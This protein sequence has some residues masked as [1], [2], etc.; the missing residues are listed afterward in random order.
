MKDCKLARQSFESLA[1][2]FPQ[3]TWVVDASGN[4]EYFNRR[5]IDYLGRMSEEIDR[6]SWA[7]LI[8]PEDLPGVV[9]A[10]E[11][12]VGTNG[13]L[14]AE[15]RVRRWDGEYRW[16]LGRAEPTRGSDG[17]LL[18]CGTLTDIEDRK[19]A[20]FALANTVDLLR[21]VCDTTPDAVY[22]KDR[23]GKYLL[24]N[25]AAA[26]FL[27]KRV[28]DILGK[29][30]AAFLEPESLRSV[31]EFDR[32]T[33]GSEVAKTEEETLTAA[34]TTRTFLTTKAPYRD[35][36]GRTIALLGISRDVTEKKRA[37][38][39]LRLRDRAIR[40]VPQG[41]VIAD[42][43]GPDT[44]IVYASPGFEQL[45]GYTSA[46]VIGKNCRFLQGPNTDLVQVSLV[47]DAIRAGK[48]CKVELLNYR[49]DGTTFWNE[50]AISPVR[51]DADRLT[52]FVAVQ[53]DVT[54]RRSLEGQL[55]QS[56][57]MEAVGRLAGGIAHDFNNILTVICG[58]SRLLLDEMP[59][60]EEWWDSIAEI[61]AAGKRAGDSIRQL[62]AFS[63]QTVLEP[64]LIDPNELVR[65]AE[66]LLRPLIGEDIELTSQLGAD[67]GCIMADAAQ[68]EQALVN[69]CVN[70][71]DAMPSG[72]ELTIRTRRKE[73]VDRSSGADPGTYAAISVTDTGH[74]MDPATQTR[75][76]EP[77][78]TTKAIGKGTGLGLSLVY[79]FVRQSGGFIEVH[80]ELG[81]GATFEIFLPAI[82][83]SEATKSKAAIRNLPMPRGSETIL[84]VEDE[85]SVRTLAAR[86]LRGCGYSVFEATDG[87]DAL[88]VAEG[89]YDGIDLVLTDVVMP[90]GMG[91]R[92]VAECV[93]ASH[94]DAKVLYVSGYTDDALVR[95]GVKEDSI[96]FLQKPFSPDSLARK[97][98]EVLDQPLVYE[99]I[100][101]GPSPLEEAVYP[102]TLLD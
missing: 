94:P 28:E 86:V 80:S 1:D 100:A 7:D 13:P 6:D 22:V 73:V 43:S 92:K 8:H 16:H 66:K 77:F 34:G 44:P 57:K 75:I 62:L 23:E 46:E 9:A 47:R 56:Q 31:R 2:A 70:A 51:D 65:D 42:A 36:S 95:H 102:Y 30:D 59:P 87:Y 45:T 48:G 55:R 93:L 61:N 32:R 58:Y 60:S 26:R 74:G 97:V 63:H 40:A 25:D 78:F 15:C 39:D 14:E 68:L 19:R 83:G 29:S 99:P 82:S 24:C 67:V 90:G 4:P 3:M 84:L 81:R 85:A 21:A 35:R 64:R 37:E 53:M 89:L 17:R 5:L 50:L 12:N 98:R 20:E 49:K 11:R 38:A 91:G 18:W 71:R 101:I 52:H 76:F 96:S 69:L 72:G 41:I 79:G 27:G 54:A 88:R 33:I 10:W